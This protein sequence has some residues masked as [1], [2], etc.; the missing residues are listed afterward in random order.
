MSAM[1]YLRRLVVFL[2]ASTPAFSSFAPAHHELHK[3]WES[4]HQERRRLNVTYNY[5][6]KFIHPEHCRY[7]SEEECKRADYER[8]M[9]VAERRLNPSVG[10]FKVLVLLIYFPE[11]DPTTRPN[12]DYF[13]TLFNGEGMSEV[14]PVGSIREWLLYNS[15]GKYNVTFDVQDWAPTDKSAATYARGDDNGRE[16]VS[17]RWSDGVPLQGILIPELQRMEAAGFD[18]SPYD[19][20]GDNIFDHLHVIHSGPP[21]ELGAFEC[22]GAVEDMIWSQGSYAAGVGTYVT[23]SGIALGGYTI[24]SAITDDVCSNT[25]TNMAVAAHEY[26]HGFK[27]ADLYDQDFSEPVTGVGGVGAFDT[28][29]YA[30]GWTRD[31]ARP[32]YLSPYTKIAADWLTPLVISENGLYAIQP[33]ELSGQVCSL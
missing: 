25:P 3:Q 15:V 9:A 26:I 27:I 11:D 16:V 20:D 6:P 33:A 13:E 23:G 18:F 17:A 29:S 32:G 22:T 8:G 19:S 2:L 10:T 4:V 7:V 5:V 30:Y 14:N 1:L 24:S 12:R 31:G 28:M 21:A